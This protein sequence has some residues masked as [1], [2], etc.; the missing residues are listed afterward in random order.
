MV[1]YRV[2]FQLVQPLEG[3]E[4]K[5]FFCMKKIILMAAFVIISYSGSHAQQASKVSRIKVDE[6]PVA[7]RIAFENDFGSIPEGGYWSV[8]FVTIREGS[9]TT[10]QPKW[11]SYHK[12]TKEEKI[13]ARYSPE[14][15]L[16]FVKGLERVQEQRGSQ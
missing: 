9:K 3:I 12:R 13:E 11:Y 14:G 10:A 6:V 16:Q 1:E 15:E 8:N 7:V 5:P 4:T 2:N